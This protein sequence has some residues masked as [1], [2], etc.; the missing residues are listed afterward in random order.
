MFLIQ[1]K[2]MWS[3]KGHTSGVLVKGYLNKTKRYP[4]QTTYR[5]GTLMDLCKRYYKEVIEPDYGPARFCVTRCNGIGVGVIVA[6]D[7]ITI[8]HT[9]WEE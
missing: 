6:A 9:E 3:K 8:C 5:D 2:T 7:P 4:A 1:A